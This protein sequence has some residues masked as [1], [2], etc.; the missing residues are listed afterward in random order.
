MADETPVVPATE[1]A[2]PAAPATATP[3]AE[4]KN[5][6]TPAEPMIPKSRFDEV[7]NR[8]KAIEDE[9][10]K[11]AKL[12]QDAEAK[13]LAD[14]GKY[15]ELYDKQQ[16]ELQTAQAEAKAAAVK[17]MQRD[18]AAKTNLPLPLAERL[19]G[20]TADEMEADAK[21]ILAALPK[22]AAPNINANSGA[23]GAPAAGQ[24]DDAKKQQM[25]DKY[26]IDPRYIQ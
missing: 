18:I 15:K 6:E 11:A 26:G 13:R 12:A 16:A 8:L 25:A 24:M 9:N 20:E 5:T 1:P 14:E 10:K 19:R 17:L 4:A 23:G 22:P 3:P 2:A 21:A 7:N